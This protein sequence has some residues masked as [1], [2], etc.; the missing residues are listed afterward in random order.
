MQVKSL[1]RILKSNGD[2]KFLPIDAR[3]LL[4]STRNK[5]Q[6]ESVPPG[7]YHH[8]ELKSVL[9]SFL[10]GL[11][12]KGKPV[13]KQILLFM[14]VDGISLTNSNSSEFWPILFRV[15]GKLSSLLRVFYCMLHY[16]FFLSYAVGYAYVFQFIRGVYR[17][18]GKPNDVN[19]FLSAFRDEFIKL[20]RSGHIF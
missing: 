14:N 5:L 17:G 16:I 6:F 15:L 9:M 10:E 7:H 2:L 1:L 8:I 11:K 20:R 3:T 18:Y 4:K 19:Q 13:P 12:S